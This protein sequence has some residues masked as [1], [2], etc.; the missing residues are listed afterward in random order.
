MNIYSDYIVKSI[1]QC[2]YMHIQERALAL[3]E[4]RPLPALHSSAD[5]RPLS[6]DDF[7]YAHEQVWSMATESTVSSPFV[8]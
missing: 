5:V 8:P 1:D 2:E 7:K 3:A 4:N 6:M